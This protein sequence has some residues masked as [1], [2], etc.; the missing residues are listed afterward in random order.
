[1]ANESQGKLQQ[2]AWRQNVHLPGFMQNPDDGTAMKSTKKTST[3]NNS[4]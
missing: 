3:S 4:R 2:K 1:M